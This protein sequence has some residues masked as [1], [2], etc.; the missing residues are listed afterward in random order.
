MT[1]TSSLLQYHGHFREAQAT[2]LLWWAGFGPKADQAR[3]VVEVI[4]QSMI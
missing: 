3:G 2:R 4:P 1:G